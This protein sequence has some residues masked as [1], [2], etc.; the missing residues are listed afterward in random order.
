MFVYDDAMTGRSATR[1]ASCTPRCSSAT[2][3]WPAS[4]PSS[5]RPGTEVRLEVDVNHRYEYV[6]ARTARLPLYNPARKTA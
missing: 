5:P 1:R 6:A 3:R 2:S 4:G